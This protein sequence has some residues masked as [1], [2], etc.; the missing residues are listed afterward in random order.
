MIFGY[1]FVICFSFFSFFIFLSK[2]KQTTRAWM[3]S[4]TR[5][6]NNTKQKGIFSS[7]RK[8]PKDKAP[9][10]ID[11]AVAEPLQKNEK[12]QVQQQQPSSPGGF[13]RPYEYIESGDTSPTRRNKTVGGFRYD[14]EPQIRQ[15]DSEG[16]QLSPNSQARRA[17]G[18]AFNYAPGEDDAVRE[19]AEKRKTGELSPKSK[20]KVLKGIDVIPVK[21]SKSYSPNSGD[22][23]VAEGAGTY[24]PITDDATDAFL[25]A[26]RNA[27]QVPLV[28]PEAKKKRVKVLAIVSKFD[29]KN[30]RIDIIN[31]K[32]DHSTGILNTDTGKIE[33][34]FGVVDPKNATVEVLNTRT[35]KT[36]TYQ[37]VLEPKTGN[38]H[39]TSGVTDL[40]TGEIDD[41]LGQVICISPE[42]PVTLE[43][44]GIAG[45]IDPSSGKLD[46]VNGSVERSR[47]VLNPT[48]SLIDTKYGLINPKTGEVTVT[49]TK[50]GKTVTKHGK[51]DPS[52]GQITIVGL[53]D[54]KGGKSDQNNQGH[55]IA[56]G[57]P[58]DPVVE[59]TAISGKLDKK[60]VI[61]AKSAFI[62]NSTGK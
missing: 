12:E 45:R 52:T 43:V 19:Q 26:E 51:L 24:R 39:I 17:T 41:T 42:S 25:G 16:G 15:H 2:L 4:N 18:L 48:T 56:F 13:T 20:E 8:S 32:V 11:I 27:S 9:K 46:T 49:D 53:T 59:V 33:T 35:G 10:T 58:I 57:A 23:P 34:K 36:D 55:L 31:G 28:V 1:N 6:R 60:G 61:D 47:G 30:K 54:A 14:D 22:R 37:G 62:E 50:S 3:P 5:K 7:G 44:T 29:K 40:K 38:I 21:T